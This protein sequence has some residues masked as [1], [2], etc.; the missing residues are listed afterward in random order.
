M[1]VNVLRVS[2]GTFATQARDG[3]IVCRHNVSVGVLDLV[4][5]ETRLTIHVSPML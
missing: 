5:F 4:S 2:A 3:T 1:L